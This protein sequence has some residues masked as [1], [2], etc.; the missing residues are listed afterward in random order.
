[1]NI[2]PFDQLAS[3]LSGSLHT[4][5]FT[6]T[7]YSTDAS[8]YQEM[9]MAVAFPEDRDD[10]LALIKFARQHGTGLI[11]RTAGTSLAGQ[12]VGSG[13]VV[14][15]S[16]TFTRILEINAEEGWARV[17]PGVIRNELNM[18][19]DPHGLM[20]A[21]ETST[22]N[23]A[24]IGGML[25]NNSCGSNSIIYGST[26]KHTLSTKGFLSDGSF[27]EFGALDPEAFKAKCNGP[28]DRLET[29]LY[30][31]AKELLADP[32]NRAEIQRKFPNPGIPRRNTGYALDLL[33]DAAVLDPA[34]DQPFNFCQLLAGSEGTL[35]FST[36]IKVNCVKIPPPAN[37]LLCAHFDSLDEALRANLLA[38]KHEI[39]GCEM[40]DHFVLECTKDNRAQ[41]A[42][43]FFVEGDPAALLIVDFRDVDEA[44]ASTRAHAL[45][46]EMKA[47]GLGSAFPVVGGADCDRV[48]DLR[49]AG[50]G[51]LSNIPGDA[52][53]VPVV[54]DTAVAVEDLPAYVAE[55]DQL[56]KKR[57]NLECV[58]YAH[59]GT[60]ELHLRPMINLKTVEGK[61]LFREVLSSVADLVREYK[62]SLSGEHGD[63]RLRGEFLEH[64]IGSHNYA[65]VRSFKQTWD[66]AGIF[67]PNKIV[68]TPPMNEQLR[69][70]PGQ[71][72]RSLDTIFDF[73]HDHGI[74]RAAERCN[75][76]GDCR[77]TELGE[78]IMCPSY[79]ATRNEKDTPRA[80]ANILRNILT[81]S[82][83]GN[84]F[85][86]AEIKE[87]MD[88]C[89]SCKGCKSECPS[90]VD[91][92]KLKAE[93]LQHYYDA[94]GIPFR[95]RMFAE[96]TRSAVLAAR[97]PWAWNAV[98]GSR[99]L[100]TIPK[101]IM[102]MAPQRTIPAAHWTTL[103]R[104]FARHRP[105]VNPGSVGKVIFFCDEFTNYQDP[106][107]GIKA[108]E[109]LESL[110]YEVKMPEHG[111]S[112]RTY[113]SKGLLRK[114]KTIANRNIRQ[115]KDRI[116]GD[117]PL[118]G[119]EPSGILG[120]RDEYPDL[121][122]P[123]LKEAAN[124]LAQNSLMIDEFLVR[125]IEAGRLT[126][127]NFTEKPQKI[128]LHGHC[129]QKSLYGTKP[130]ERVLSLPENY[131]VEVVPS[132]CCGMAGSF[133]FE[134]EHYETSMKV[135]ELVLFPAV[136]R[137]PDDVLISA[138][139][140]SCRHQIKDGTGRNVL[141][142]VEILHAAVRSRL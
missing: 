9:P 49:K 114:A 83:K 21:P 117:I 102:D 133:G 134:K 94:N 32:Q 34:S 81:Q 132:G 38:V 4:D 23:R 73:G 53:P 77:K 128:L 51:L 120:F 30:R 142:P 96:F 19:L 46:E 26:R 55:F 45:G 52:K 71:Q 62:G 22:Q 3:A 68:D 116:D 119:I 130:M 82:S 109:L 89:L 123:D 6:R 70:A 24:M 92:C 58:H 118:V 129:H 48:W 87:V 113:L 10:L 78:G 2:P 85:D 50:L 57:F 122:D 136:R 115:F 126:E 69:Y 80:R 103:R 100:S 93:F 104:W 28:G 40:M 27:V 75:G 43:R 14:D 127:S 95:T 91:I 64:M 90:S 44:T 141:H 60:G 41:L 7:L 121:A 12:V 47:A 112:A 56:M 110:G 106:Q 15:I 36:E 98:F 135:G 105:P 33:M 20:F 8:A 42:N 1:M 97:M 63:G 131:E 125:E 13:I 5:E 66:P 65:L 59:V 74:L 79:M 67:N 72:T 139:G 138:P 107:V 101:A 16:R 61:N 37:A 18:A 84:P 25:G 35:F 99:L 17:E 108:V 54:E 137:Q 29:R 86:S 140:T 88:L 76:S 39:H 124:A 31:H 111:E 11:P